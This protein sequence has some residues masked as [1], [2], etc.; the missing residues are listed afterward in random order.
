MV[1]KGNNNSLAKP[2]LQKWKTW[3]CFGTQTKS[4]LNN[5][6]LKLVRAKFSWRLAWDAHSCHSSRLHLN[7][8]SLAGLQL[9]EHHTFEAVQKYST[10]TILI[11]NRS[12]YKGTD[13]HIFSVLMGVIHA[14]GYFANVVIYFSSFLYTHDHL[15]Y[16]LI[17]CGILVELRRLA[18]HYA[19]PN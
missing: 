15:S 16:S 17:F 10:A 1:W 4:F 9:N 11:L 6:Q 8:S 18:F 19:L 13:D 5:K 14:L 2:K 3:H 12:T 7:K